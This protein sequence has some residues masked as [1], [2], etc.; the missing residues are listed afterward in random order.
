MGLDSTFVLEGL[1][2]TST[3]EEW[4]GVFHSDYGPR[5]TDGRRATERNY[6]F[7]SSLEAWSSKPGD[8]GAGDL[9]QKCADEK[10]LFQRTD[11]SQLGR[12]FVGKDSNGGIEGIVPLENFCEEWFAS[13]GL[14]MPDVPIDELFEFGLMLPFSRYRIVFNIS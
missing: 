8:C 3:G 1:L 7:F 10:Y 2:A 6:E 11:L 12:H 13:R 4:V 9:Y 5:P 14:A